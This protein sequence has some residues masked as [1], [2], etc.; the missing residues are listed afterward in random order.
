VFSGVLANVFC[1]F[2][3]AEVWSTH[4][5]EMCGLRALLRQRL[6]K[7][8]P[9]IFALSGLAVNSS[10]CRLNPVDAIHHGLE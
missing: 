10:L 2:H 8:L 5:A 7:L 6:T 9:I 3:A 4:A 1:D